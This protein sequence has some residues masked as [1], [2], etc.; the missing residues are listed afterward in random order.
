MVATLPL[1]VLLV[2]L[3]IHYHL[4]VLLCGVEK[5]N[6]VETRAAAEEESILLCLH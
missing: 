4:A 1:K 5:V 6:T 3:V 2:F